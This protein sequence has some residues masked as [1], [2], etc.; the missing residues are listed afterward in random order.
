MNKKKPLVIKCKLKHC[1]N[2]EKGV[3]EAG[4]PNVMQQVRP[5][6]KNCPFYDD[7]FDKTWKS[8][9]KSGGVLGAILRSKGKHTEE[10]LKEAKKKM[11]KPRKDKGK[12]RKGGKK[13]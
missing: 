9:K 6:T 1:L 12:K 3:C 4:S 10:D 5:N 13:S 2:C 7:N 11:R 8:F